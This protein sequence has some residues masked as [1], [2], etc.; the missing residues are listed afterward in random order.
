MP[1]VWWAQVKAVIRLE[2]R[3]TFFARRGL[4]LYFLALLPVL[5]FVG[6]SI[7]NSFQ[8]KQSSSIARRS[9]KAASYQDLMAIHSG[10][11]KEE[12]LSTLGKPPVVFHWEVRRDDESGKPTVIQHEEYRY[13]DGVNDL[14]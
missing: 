4:W 1:R 13:S 14:Y 12:I 5:L 2:L 9:E 10:M 8:L 6:Y 7:T 11:T 3:K